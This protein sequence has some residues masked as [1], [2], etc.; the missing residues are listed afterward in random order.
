M[1]IGKDCYDN[2]SPFYKIFYKMLS[3]SRSVF[4]NKVIGAGFSGRE[5]EYKYNYSII[6]IESISSVNVAKTRTEIVVYCDHN[7]YARK[8]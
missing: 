6:T 4:W 8:N 2:G 1:I 7:K 5:R 3:R